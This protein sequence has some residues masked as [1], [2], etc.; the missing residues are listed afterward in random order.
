M[1]N[2]DLI[3]SLQSSYNDNLNE[4]RRIEKFLYDNEIDFYDVD[5]QESLSSDLQSFLTIQ[6]QKL[7]QHPLIVKTILHLQQQLDNIDF[8]NSVI[9]VELQKLKDKNSELTH[10]LRQIFGFKQATL[11]TIKPAQNIFDFLDSLSCTYKQEQN[12]LLVAFKVDNPDIN[13]LKQKYS[14][15][16]EELKILNFSGLSYFI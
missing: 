12:K 9:K 3:L 13:I 5:N 11:I 10:Q 15:L 4:I 14:I 6:E 8:H 16:N 7:Q 2:L 1:L